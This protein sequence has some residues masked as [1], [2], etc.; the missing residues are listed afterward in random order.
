MCFLLKYVWN[1]WKQL[2]AYVCYA[3]K[4]YRTILLICTGISSEIWILDLFDST[5]C[6]EKY[7]CST[8]N[9]V[10][11]NFNTL[12][13]HKKLD[14]GKE[15]KFACKLCGYTCKRRTQMKNHWGSKHYGIDFHSIE[16]L[17]FLVPKS[18]PV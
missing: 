5:T 4:F 18:N 15:A 13:S 14:C 12:R 1:F 2:F 9:K 16:Q 3:V 10:Y 8:C 17:V 6:T 7:V 11:K